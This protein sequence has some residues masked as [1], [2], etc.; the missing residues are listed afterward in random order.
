VTTG[1]TLGGSLPTAHGW[2][3]T[4]KRWDPKRNGHFWPIL[5]VVG[6]VVAANAPYVLGLFKPN[7]LTLEAGVS[8][9]TR[10]GLLPGLPWIDPNSGITAQALGHLAAHDWLHG[11]VPWWNPYEGLGAPLAGEMQSAA[12]FPPTLLLIFT[13]GQVYFHLLLELAA[14]LATY[15]FLVQLRVGRFIAAAGAISF[16]L[17]GAFAWFDH[18]PVNPV[19]FLPLVLW[20]VERGFTGPG[21]RRPSS[22]ILISAG[23]ALSLYAGFPETAYID[24]ILA[25][26][27]ALVRLCQLPKGRRSEYFV[28]LAAGF[29]VG[30][31]IAAP[32]LTSF[33]EYLGVANVGSHSGVF[34]ATSLPSSIFPQL[35][36]PYLFG[37]IS[38]FS[39]NDPS[40]VLNGAWGQV[41]GYLSVPLIVLG[42]IGVAG[43]QNR[44]LRVLLALWLIVALGRTY[45]VPPFQSII[46][47]LPGMKDV[48]FFRYSMSSCALALIVLAVFGID[49]L[50]RSLVSRRVTIVAGA[51]GLVLVGGSIL[52]ARGLLRNLITAHDHNLW[53]DTSEAWAIATVLL[54]IAISIGLKGRRRLC[55]LAALV[56]LDAFAMFVVPEFSA[57]RG[58]NVYLAPATYLA[59]HLGTS[60]YYTVGP[61]P[62]N[63][64]SYFG[65]AEFNS[66]DL[67][68]PKAYDTLAV[69][70]FDLSLNGADTT[71]AQQATNFLDRLGQFESVGVKYLLTP[72][73]FQLPAAPNAS[74]MR[75]VESGPSGEI[76]E[77]PS[78]KQ[79][80]RADG[81]GCRVESQTISSATVHCASSGTLYREEL[82]MSGWT[83]TIGQRTV[84]VDPAGI[85]Q[86]VALPPGTSSVTFFFAPPGA[87]WAL[88]GFV[89]GALTWV[90]G[91]YLVIRHR[92]RNRVTSLGALSP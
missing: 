49:D 35:V 26:L 66:N 27:W 75:L 3:L 8:A 10:G 47:L 73:G 1:T 61:L 41:G 57:P 56:G 34:G 20:G 54:V 51:I 31:L 23:I 30:L 43:R 52:E 58:E 71:A 24:G 9:I 77:V 82:Y 16:A 86:R 64:G 44:P 6:V 45:G 25:G 36:M 2:A 22:W 79:L 80:Y 37:P 18:A 42:T 87:D 89:L 59:E 62:A 72:G 19:A 63:Y 11:Q 92:A 4:I 90:G 50:R 33:A 88:A 84:N 67:P 74:K 28:T 17:S 68:E 69:H 85:Y 53:A 40:G 83:A 29:T 70:S 48:A 76:F 38:A 55:L 78:P 12:L 81:G 32:I 13:N 14:A 21:L 65:A 60:R 91:L 39:G 15:G 5:V 7:P 46:N